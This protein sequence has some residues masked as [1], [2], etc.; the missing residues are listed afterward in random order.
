MKCAIQPS[1]RLPPIAPAS[2]T[3]GFIAGRP[4]IGAAHGPTAVITTV[5]T[6]PATSCGERGVL[7]I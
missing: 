2:I 3:A 7:R 5:A 4:I 1:G 6:N